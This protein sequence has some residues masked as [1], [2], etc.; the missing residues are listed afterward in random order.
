MNLILLSND[1]LFS[2]ISLKDRP[3]QGLNNAKHF[4]LVVALGNFYFE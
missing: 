3:R 1:P 4:D 2:K